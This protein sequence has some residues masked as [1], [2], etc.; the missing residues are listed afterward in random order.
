M[1]R[2]WSKTKCI[3]LANLVLAVSLFLGPGQAHSQDA[4]ALVVGVIDMQ[5]ILRES[6]AVQ[7]LSAA[8]ETRRDAYQEELREKEE[9]FRS[10]D[11]ELARQRSEFTPE[12]FAQ[13]RRELEQRA[14][15]LQRDFAERKKELDQLFGR[16]MAQVQ[17]TLVQVSQ[18]I[19]TERGLDI[20]LAKSTVVLVKPSLEITNEALARLNEN[21]PDVALPDADEQVPQN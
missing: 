3:L 16:G 18:E 7:S 10:A 15:Q 1:A 8:V 13:K 9:A 11:L 2:A 14:S 12:R 5:R 20:L 19:A 17:Q 21:L 4:P 6:I